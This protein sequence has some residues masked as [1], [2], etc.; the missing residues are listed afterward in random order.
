MSQS[1]STLVEDHDISVYLTHGG[2]VTKQRIYYVLAGASLSTH[3]QCS[4]SWSGPKR[5]KSVDGSD[6]KVILKSML[7]R[8]FTETFGPATHTICVVNNMEKTNIVTF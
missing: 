6:A 5:D 2:G 7:P 3:S 1:Y 8:N 4:L